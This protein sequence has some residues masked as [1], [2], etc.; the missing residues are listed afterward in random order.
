MAGICACL[1][2]F[3]KKITMPDIVFIKAGRKR[4]RQHFSPPLGIMS[5]AAYLKDNVPDTRIKIIDMVPQGLD[6]DGAAKEAVSFAPDIIGISAMSHEADDMF[7]LAAKLKK[8][9]PKTPVAT[10]GPHTTVSPENVLSNESIDYAVMGEGELIFPDLM[11]VILKDKPEEKVTGIGYKKDSQIFINPKREEIVDMDSLPL[12]AY[13]LIDLPRYWD[14]TRFGT[15][16]VS[17]EYAVLST[18]R[19]CPYGCTYCHRIFGTRFRSQSAK[20]VV[21]DLKLLRDNFGVKEIQFVDD[22]F[23]L[24]KKRVAEIADGIKKEGLNFAITFPNG[25]RGDIVDEETLDKMKEMGTYRI[26]YAIETASPRLQEF[27]SKH[28]KLDKLKEVIRQTDKRDIMVDGFFML[29][30]PGETKEEIQKTLDY[31][32]KSSLHSANFFFVTPFKGTRLYDQAIEM[33]YNIDEQTAGLHYFDP[34]TGLSEVPPDELNKMV[35]KNIFK[36]YLNPWRVWRILKLF[37]NK[38][39][40]PGLFGRFLKISVLG[41]S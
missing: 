15:A 25:I 14:L 30:F 37:P 3:L 20:T 39:Q 17:K 27:L 12:P 36:F 8:L 32:L 16:Y 35:R 23:N 31:S 18:S 21:R 1:K 11:D 28:V 5:L 40:L 26:T 13:D 38:K 6:I 2:F 34:R 41:E 4:P 10:G 24:S 9:S 29:G 22:C 7:K 19:A 33:G